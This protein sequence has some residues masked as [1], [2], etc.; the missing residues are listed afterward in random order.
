MGGKISTGDDRAEAEIPEDGTPIE[1]TDGGG[2]TRHDIRPT[3]DRPYE[4]ATRLL[5]I[6]NAILPVFFAWQVEILFYF[7]TKQWY[8]VSLDPFDWYHIVMIG[9]FLICWATSAAILIRD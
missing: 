8:W 4:N 1:M 9:C 2:H 5:A 7:E 6:G 3:A